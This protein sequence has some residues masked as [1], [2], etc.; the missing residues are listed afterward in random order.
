MNAT[1]R[2]LIQALLYGA[3]M[4]MI[5][6][7]S[8]SP[9]YTHLAPDLALVKLSFSHGAKPLHPCRQRSAEELAK[10]SPNMRAPL[11]CSRERAPVIVE[12][13]ID[14]Q[15]LVRVS[16]PPAGLAKDGP[17]TLYRRIPVTAGRH[18]LVARLS[19]DPSGNF[20]YTRS[21]VVELQAGRIL[22][23][24]FLPAE[25]GFVFTS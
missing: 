24:D 10:L 9:R 18:Q 12:L 25:G 19:D 6:Y 17:A 11:D 8:T 22:I 13:E 1:A 2:Y 5:G 16:V 20:N 21:A 7:F 15:P 23:I 14:G 4:A 3:F